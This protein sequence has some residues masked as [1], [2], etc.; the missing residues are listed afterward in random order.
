MKSRKGVN[1]LKLN[2]MGLLQQFGRALMLPMIVLPIAALFIALS[3]WFSGPL[4]LPFWSEL[5]KVAGESI[6]LFLPSIFAVGVALALTENAGVAGMS[7]VLGYI[8]FIQIMNLS[9]QPVQFGVSGGIMIGILAA[10]CH[11]RFKSIRLP[12]SLQFF[13]GPRFVPIAMSFATVALSILMLWVGPYMQLALQK[14]SE[15]MISTGAF[16]AFLFGIAHRL[17]VPFGLHHIVSNFAWFQ[18]GTFERSDGLLMFGDLTRFFGGDP[19]AGMY[20]TGFYW[21]K[22]FGLPAAALAMYHEVWPQ[23]RSKLRKRFLNAAIVS[24]LIGVTEPI[25]FLFL[26]VAPGL[27]VLHALLNGVAMALAVE[28]NI[29]HG[30]GFSAGLFDYVINFPLSTN[31]LMILPYGLAFAFVYYTSFRLWIRL[32]NVPTPGRERQVNQ[33]NGQISLFA[34]AEAVL[35]AIGGRENIVNLEA[36]ITRLRLTVVDERKLNQKALLQLGAS[37]MIHLGG[38]NVQVVFGTLAELLSVKIHDILRGTVINEVRH[39]DAWVAPISGQLI[40]LSDVPDAVFSQGLVGKGIAIDPGDVD[41]FDVVAPANAKVIMISESGHAIGLRTNEGIEMLIHIG[42]DSVHAKGKGFNMM[43][44]LDDEVN[45]G[46]LL[47]HVNAILLRPLCKSL[48]TP[49]IVPDQAMNGDSSGIS[50]SIV[51]IEPGEHIQ[52]GQD[53]ITG[54]TSA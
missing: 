43:V 16:G 50:K 48:I 39:E 46:Q 12:E 22:M 1:T 41:A 34:Q 3:H 35:E 6:F 26:I 40:A 4:D 11:H 51:W 5:F 9:E 19:Q 33:V 17:L 30:F 28:M 20:M 38:G 54:G 27:F 31:G 37:G 44:L 29:H 21:I 2:F 14:S 8:L 36:C 15:A 53:H 52:A 10:L 7:A 47:V 23:N 13:G 42:I 25:E 24:L 45:K 49:I 32:R 18:V